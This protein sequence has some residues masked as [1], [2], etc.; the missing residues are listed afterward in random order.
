VLPRPT[1]AEPAR[2]PQRDHPGQ[3]Q[4]HRSTKTDTHVAAWAATSNVELAYVPCY[5]PWLNSIEAQFTALRYFALD[6]TD[7]D[8]HR[9]QASLTRRYIIWRNTHV[10]DPRL[11]KVVKRAATI[12]RPRLPDAVPASA[13]P[14]K[15]RAG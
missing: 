5:G 11:R 6:G 9:E 3:L 1:F 7:H 10:T 15:S 8:S 12:K 14:V 13:A 4:S 2:G